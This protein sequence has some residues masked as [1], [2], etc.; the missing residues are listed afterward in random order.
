MYIYLLHYC[1]STHP[2]T[3]CTGLFINLYSVPD[4]IILYTDMAAFG[5]GSN[6]FGSKPAT[7]TATTTAATGFAGLKLPTASTAA[8]I[9]NSVTMLSVTHFMKV[10]ATNCRLRIVELHVMQF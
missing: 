8:A 6:L 2:S 4:N 7:T 9:G 10:Y 3:I 1:C 5:T